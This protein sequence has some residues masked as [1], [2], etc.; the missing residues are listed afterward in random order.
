MKIYII[1]IKKFKLIKVKSGNTTNY[2]IKQDFKRKSFGY[3]I[4][5]HA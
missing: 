1:K 5:Y 3:N 4:S 2:T